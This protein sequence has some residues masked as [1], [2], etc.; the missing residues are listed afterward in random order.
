MNDSFNK[1]LYAKVEDEARANK[2]EFV[3]GQVPTAAVAVAG[4]LIWLEFLR[5]DGRLFL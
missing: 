4:G 5:F 3:V 2:L 1:K